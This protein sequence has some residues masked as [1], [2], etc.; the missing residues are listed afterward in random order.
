MTEKPPTTADARRVLWRLTLVMPPV[1]WGMG[2]L[3]ALSGGLSTAEAATRATAVAL[4]W[5]AGWA[6]YLLIARPLAG[7]S[8]ATIP[9]SIVGISILRP[10]RTSWP[11]PDMLAH[12]VVGSILV[13]MVLALIHRL[14]WRGKGARPPEAHPLANAEV[15]RA[16]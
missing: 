9:L 15:D 2:F 6:A 4:S 11:L 14:V 3:F 16:G 5:F 13:A 7:S 1:Q 12:G 8:F 10:T